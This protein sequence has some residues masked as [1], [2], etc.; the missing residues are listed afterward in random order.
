MAYRHLL[1]PTDGS[2]RSR[3]A[4]RIAVR[5]AHAFGARLTGIYVVAEGV[6][7]LFSGNKL[8]GSGVRSREYRVLVKRQAQSVLMEVEREASAANVPCRTVWRLARE[9]WRAILGAARA[10][11]CDLIVMGSHGRGG[12]QSLLL[13]SQ[14][15]K[16]L[17]HSRIPA[18]VC[19]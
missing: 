8:Y 10:G 6:P 18:L 13:G 3:R 14:T 12:V 4:I 1:V 15:V 2:N 7:T 16:V 19:R 11:G 5:L 17:A 9:P